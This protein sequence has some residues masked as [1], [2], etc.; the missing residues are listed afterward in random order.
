MLKIF[1]LVTGEYFSINSFIIVLKFTAKDC[2]L[3]YERLMDS[4]L[5]FY[6]VEL[7]QGYNVYIIYFV[8][9]DTLI[10]SYISRMIIVFLLIYTHN[11]NNNNDNNWK[12]K[13]SLWIPNLIDRRVNRE[14][15][16]IYK[17]VSIPF[18]ARIFMY[19]CF[20]DYLWFT[21]VFE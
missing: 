16:R 12:R 6:C 21:G 19:N 20:R 18:W 2:I 17:R 3:C 10:Y 14:S 8:G 1:F 13:R 4:Y 11:N 5:F 15:R 9:V 7:F